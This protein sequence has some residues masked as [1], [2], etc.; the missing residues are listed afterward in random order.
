MTDHCRICDKDFTSASF[1]G[2][3][4]CPACDC[5]FNPEADAAYQ[6]GYRAGIAAERARLLP[7]LKELLRLY[8]WRFELADREKADGEHYG[9]NN[10]SPETKAM[11]RQYGEEKKAAWAAARAKLGEI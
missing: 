7:V 1:G 11:L 6:R 4:V 3:G 9:Q 10:K 8:D 2:P 5:G